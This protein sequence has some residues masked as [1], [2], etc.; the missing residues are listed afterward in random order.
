[1]IFSGPK[2]IVFEG[3]DG[4]GKSTLSE[5]LYD[6]LL[7]INVPAVKGQEPTDGRWG[8]QIRKLLKSDTPPPIEEQMKLFLFDREEDAERNI[9]PRLKDGNLTDRDSPPTHHVVQR[10]AAQRQLARW[11]I[12][13]R[14]SLTSDTVSVALFWPR[15]RQELSESRRRRRGITKIGRAVRVV[16]GVSRGAACQRK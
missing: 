5:M 11:P 6:Y 4:S 9:R 10:C 12:R 7:S 3:I 1:M 16:P 13:G 8:R 2:F 14:A 15:L